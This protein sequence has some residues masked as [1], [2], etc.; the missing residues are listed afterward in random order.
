MGLWKRIAWVV[1]LGIALA[2][3]LASP[4]WAGAFE[5]VSA[6]RVASQRGHYGEAIRLFSQAIE[7]GEL[8]TSLL[9]ITYFNRGNINARMGHQHAALADF[10]AA[11]RLRPDY[12]RAYR[13]RGIIDYVMRRYPEAIA[14]FTKVLTLKP[15][16][17][18]IHVRRA[19]VYRSMGR[20]DLA[21]AD[22]DRAIALKPDYWMA[23]IF[24]G[25]IHRRAGKFTLALADF[26]RV[27]AG[28]PRSWDGYIGRCLTYERMG[29]KA[30]AI[31]DCRAALRLY[32]NLLE[33]ENALQRMGAPEIRQD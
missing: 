10:S 33:A 29:R 3:V 21:V 22:Y 30:A 26:S 9:A 15:D 2:P 20:D 1:V 7:S 25:N 11:I 31:G 8:S 4:V 32:P 13:E 18:E 28:N 23:Y 27:I 5:D 14:D 17:P 6:G 19:G 16:E 24:R 12:V